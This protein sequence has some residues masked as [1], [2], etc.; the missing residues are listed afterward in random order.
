MATFSTKKYIKTFEYCIHWNINIRKNKF[1]SEKINGSVEWNKNISVKRSEGGSSAISFS[2]FHQQVLCNVTSSFKSI[3][4]SKSKPALHRSLSYI[5]K[6]ISSFSLSYIV[7]KVLFFDYH[8][9]LNHRWCIVR[10]ERKDEID[11]KKR[12][13]TRNEIDKK[14]YK[15]KHKFSQKRT[16]NCCIQALLHTYRNQKKNL[17][18]TNK[19][20]L[21]KWKN[22]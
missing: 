6:S 22:I 1:I 14:E 21:L 13:I 8:S 18:F 12:Y 10:E 2:S 15:D 16:K 19:G 7:F 5:Q 3:K 4:K 17:F 9:D 11:K 20:D